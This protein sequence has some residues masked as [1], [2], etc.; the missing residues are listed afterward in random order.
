MECSCC[1]RTMSKIQ[2]SKNQLK[3]KNSRCKEC[4]ENIQRKNK[5]AKNRE[6]EIFEDD[7]HI[8]EEIFEDVPPRRVVMTPLSYCDL[9]EK[10][11]DY[12]TNMSF[13]DFYLCP[14]IG[15]QYCKKCEQ[16]CKK[17]L[18][19]FSIS[20]EIIQKSFPDNEFK[21]VRSNKDIET[22]WYIASNAVRYNTTNDYVVAIHNTKQVTIKKNIELELLKSWQL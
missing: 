15:W 19:R 8:E 14:H 6:E 10:M 21:V 7:K 20:K 9:C 4:I 16:K 12:A 2:F 5:E 22:G 18:E 1:K 11:V 17:N 3:K 13:I